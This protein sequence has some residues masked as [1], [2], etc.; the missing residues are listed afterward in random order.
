LGSQAPDLQDLS[1]DIRTLAL[2]RW[3]RSL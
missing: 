3:P 2:M 1:S